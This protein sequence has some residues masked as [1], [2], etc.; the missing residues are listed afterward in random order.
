MENTYRK[1]RK[2]LRIIQ[3][4]KN[5]NRD[6]FLSNTNTIYFNRSKSEGAVDKSNHIHFLSRSFANLSFAASI[7]LQFCLRG[8]SV[9]LFFLDSRSCSSSDTVLP[10]L[11]ESILSHDD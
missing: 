3:Q 9:P 2:K 6:A 4:N 1:I 5:I 8:V 10:N 7:F 11:S